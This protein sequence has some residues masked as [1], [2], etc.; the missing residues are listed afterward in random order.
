MRS[1]TMLSTAKGSVGLPIHG[2]H[3]S[4]IVYD[5][6]TPESKTNNQGSSNADVLIPIPKLAQHG[7]RCHSHI[8]TGQLPLTSQ[9]LPFS[10]WPLY[11]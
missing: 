11:P 1:Y 2:Q 5:I 3:L 8:H 7:W 9:G 6:T 4:H 10:T